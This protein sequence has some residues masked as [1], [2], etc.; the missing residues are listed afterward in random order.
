M[1]KA[2]ID[3]VGSS[4][5]ITGV[6]SVPVGSDYHHHHDLSPV[7]VLEGALHNLPDH[8]S[9]TAAK[10]ILSLAT[11]ATASDLFVV[12]VT[13]GGSAL[14]SLSEDGITIDEKKLTIASLANAGA[15]IQE[16]NRVRQCIS[17]TKAGKLGMAAYPAKVLSLILSD[18]IGDPLEVIASGPTVLQ[19]T[20]PQQ[21]IDILH[22]YDITNLISDSVLTYLTRLKEITIPP[23]TSQRHHIINLLVGNN[24]IATK[25][26]DETATSLGYLTKVWSCGIT[27][28]AK[29]IGEVY[30]QSLYHLVFQE[31]YLMNT[32]DSVSPK[33]LNQFSKTMQ[34]FTRTTTTPIC[35]LGGGEPV[36]HVKGTGKGG[37]NQELVLSALI[38]LSL[39]DKARIDRLPDFLIASVGTD[40]QDGPTEY[41][42]AYI[43]KSTL[44]H[45]IECGLH[46]NSY[47]DN[48]DSTIFF[49]LLN[50]GK[51]LIHIGPTGTN[52]MDLHIVIVK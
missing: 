5:V 23:T 25:V 3:T 40:G 2:V 46:A 50:N 38:S 16:V 33:L 15:S 22:K 10:E 47:L 18:I 51:N 42:G 34:D 32:G 7:R 21:C 49:E 4:N 45:Y 20:Y 28:E 39:L 43:D 19:H 17:K 27:G 44:L 13:G 29:S 48:N 30:A 8:N 12:L 41:A 11:S 24:K 36:V 1:V 37:R 26:A 31:A 9:E 35:I 52:V 6:A 14:L